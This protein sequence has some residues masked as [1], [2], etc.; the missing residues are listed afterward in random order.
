MPVSP[1]NVGIVPNL[2][3]L[4][5]NV[6]GT[7][8]LQMGMNCN[9]LL[10]L[11]HHSPRYCMILEASGQRLWQQKTHC[12]D[13]F[14]HLIWLLIT[15]QAVPPLTWIFLFGCMTWK[16]ITHLTCNMFLAISS[17]TILLNHLQNLPVN[18]HGFSPME[19]TDF[20]CWSFSK[21]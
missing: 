4:V 18:L 15:G 1:P 20:P 10:C 21:P 17:G 3:L 9:F 16:W 8:W 7:W 12:I 19:P 14:C 5:E 13:Q 6:H 11:R 2:G